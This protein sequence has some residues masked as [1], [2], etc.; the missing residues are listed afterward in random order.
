[1][2]AALPERNTM[3]ESFKKKLIG[4]DPLKGSQL[5]PT[6]KG[7]YQKYKNARSKLKFLLEYLVE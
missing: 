2:S 4:G 3:N 1:M 6:F 5:T 7:R